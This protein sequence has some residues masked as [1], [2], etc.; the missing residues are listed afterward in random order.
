MTTWPP[1]RRRLGT[2]H[3]GRP[4]RSEGA[5]EGGRSRDAAPTGMGRVHVQPPARFSSS[6][7]VAQSTTQSPTSVRRSGSST[8]LISLDSATATSAP[9]RRCASRCAGGARSRRRR[10]RRRSPLAAKLPHTLSG[11]RPPEP[12][13]P[14]P[15]FDY[16][17]FDRRWV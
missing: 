4:S 2:F 11:G 10:P 3:F 17:C 12:P 13:S 7:P 9:K 1:K 15:A 6:R 8:P 16:S 5:T 14:A